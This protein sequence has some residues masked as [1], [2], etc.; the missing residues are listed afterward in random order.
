MTTAPTLP[1]FDAAGTD[2]DRVT[3]ALAEAVAHAEAGRPVPGNLLRSWRQLIPFHRR[4]AAA[5]ETGLEGSA[6]AAAKWTEAEVAAV[7]KAI[8]DV[9]SRTR[10]LTADD[11]WAELGDGFLVTKGLAA[12][13]VSASFAGVIINGGRTTTS[14]RTG[15]HGKGQRLTVW[16]SLLI[17]PDDELHADDTASV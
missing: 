7:D 14:T 17:G 12:R 9:A 1:V 15:D 16:R 11:I 13:L 10:E 3:A 2:S 6:R 4:P 5:T 8:V